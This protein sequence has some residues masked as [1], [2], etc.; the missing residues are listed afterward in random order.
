MRKFLFLAVL[1]IVASVHAQ[2]SP[3]PPAQR[4]R[5]GHR[6]AIYPRPFGNGYC[7]GTE[8]LPFDR[9]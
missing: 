9:M 7:T 1:S 4:A 8:T 6:G 5:P 2:D 3:I